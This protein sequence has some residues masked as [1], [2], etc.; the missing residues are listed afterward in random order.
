MQAEDT[1]EP[2][3]R[4]VI[5]PNKTSL[6]CLYVTTMVGRRMME[7]EVDERKELVFPSNLMQAEDTRDPLQWVVI[8]PN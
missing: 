2:L 6:W 3:Q 4:V 7:E 1:W 8:M 5:T